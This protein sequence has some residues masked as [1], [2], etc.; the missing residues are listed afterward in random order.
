MGPAFVADKAVSEEDV[1]CEVAGVELITGAQENVLTDVETL[2]GTVGGDVD[3]T[4]S[5]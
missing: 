1:G 3:E 4:I 5:V 2:V